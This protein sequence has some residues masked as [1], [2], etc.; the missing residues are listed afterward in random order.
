MQGIE[1]AAVFLAK[2]LSR[3]APQ[4]RGRSIRAGGIGHLVELVCGGH[5]PRAARVG[6]QGNIYL[7]NDSGPYVLWR[8]L[9]HAGRCDTYGAVRII[10]RYARL[11]YRCADFGCI[12]RRKTRFYELD[13]AALA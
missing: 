3:V 12:A 1:V 2:Q 5:R 6:A 7:N 8:F 11:L 9:R 13:E 10:S 4:F